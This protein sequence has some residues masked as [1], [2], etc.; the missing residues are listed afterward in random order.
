[1]EILTKVGCVQSYQF[2]KLDQLQLLLLIS[3]V[4]LDVYRKE[5]FKVEMLNRM[6]VG[7]V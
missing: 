5:D 4:K 6:E 3:M 2:K 1:M 7:Y